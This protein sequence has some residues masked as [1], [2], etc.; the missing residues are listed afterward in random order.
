[1]NT[2]INTEGITHPK[3]LAFLEN[4]PKFMSIVATCEAIG[5]RH[6]T[7]YRWLA[8]EDSFKAQCEALKKEIED[9]RLALY[10]AELDKRALHGS[11]QSDILL[12]FGLKALNPGKYREN[13]NIKHEGKIELAA[14]ATEYIVEGQY[15]EIEGSTQQMLSVEATESTVV[16]L[17][18]ESN[19]RV[20]E[21]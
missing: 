19:S 3:Q 17:K 10:E 12:M 21:E 11:K 15:R 16:P 9:K 7:Y 6:Q 5:I 14:V 18:E 4:Y 2:D 1:M 20:P 8:S 13:I